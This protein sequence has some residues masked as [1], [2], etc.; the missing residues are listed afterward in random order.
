MPRQKSHRLVDSN[1]PN[2]WGFLNNYSLVIVLIASDPRILQ[3]VIADRIGIT[4][5]AVQRIVADLETAGYLKR[6]RQGRS[7]HYEIQPHRKLRDE[8]CSHVSL[9]EFIGLLIE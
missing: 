7:N 8:T 1:A 2:G 6:R 9:G 3:R 5:R 4:E